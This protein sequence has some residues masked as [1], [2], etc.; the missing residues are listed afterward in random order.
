MVLKRWWVFDGFIFS[1]VLQLH[2]F[3]ELK[4]YI[5]HATNAFLSPDWRWSCLT[6]SPHTSINSQQLLLRGEL[7]FIWFL[8]FTLFFQ[9]P[10]FFN[11]KL[12]GLHDISHN[13]APVPKLKLQSYVLIWKHKKHSMTRTVLHMSWV[14]S[15][16]SYFVCRHNRHVKLSPGLRICQRWWVS[17]LK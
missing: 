2:I 5:I 17:W 1:V 16:S 11:K 7:V 9:L 15:F 4:S 6:P 13:S 12:Q 10:T 14:V 8:L 3:I